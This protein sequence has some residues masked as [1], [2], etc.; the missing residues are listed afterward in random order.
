MHEPAHPSPQPDTPRAAE[1]RLPEPRLVSGVY[2]LVLASALAAALDSPDEQTSPG[3]DALWV[4]LTALAAAAAHGY[5]HVLSH[6]MSGEPG[7][8][9]AG[10]RAMFAQWPLVAAA[11]PTIVLLLFAVPDWWTEASAV[12]VALV[13]NTLILAGWGMWT[14]RRAGRTWP[15]AMRAGA[16]DMLIG[17]VIIGANAVIK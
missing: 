1:R 7:G 16:A 10:L 11:A 3:S 9:R 4:L 12:E 2:G 14:A 8:M 13:L 15:A 17:L 5:A 6:R